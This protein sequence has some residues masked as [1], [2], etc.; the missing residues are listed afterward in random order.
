MEAQGVAQAI[1]EEDLQNG[2]TPAPKKRLNQNAKPKKGS[3]K[4]FM[5]R[6][7]V[8]EDCEDDEEAA[9]KQKAGK[10]K[11]NVANKEKAGKKQKE[12]AK[13]EKKAANK[14][15]KAAKKEKKAVNKEEK[16]QVMKHAD[17]VT[18]HGSINDDSGRMDIKA[19]R[20]MPDGSYKTMGIL[21]MINK[22]GYEDAIW[23]TL[24]ETMKEQSGKCT[25]RGMVALRDELVASHES[26]IVVD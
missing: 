19:K 17:A 23:K 18:A 9:K 2:L 20:M 7:M 13:K 14:E 24:L 11:E 16:V 15:K 1:L 3:R 10:K 4:A 6:R 26:A 12:A 22:N 8:E 5:I 25:K 21:G